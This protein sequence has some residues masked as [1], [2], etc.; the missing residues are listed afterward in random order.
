M[1][2][3]GR[4]LSCH[5]VGCSVSRNQFFKVLNIGFATF[6]LSSIAG[7]VS[8]DSRQ[9]ESELANCSR[10]VAERYG[11]PVL[12]IELI[13]KHLEA[14]EVGKVSHNNNDSYDMGP[15]QINSIHL[16]ELERYGYTAERLINDGCVNIVIGGWLLARQIRHRRSFA[17]GLTAYH[18]H[19][20]TPALSYLKRAYG[21]LLESPLIR[22]EIVLK[23]DLRSN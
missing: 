15:M 18:S 12:L 16:P 10:V 5:S 3:S 19:T 22:S 4:T 8:A 1:N 2:S 23:T 6:L 11:I 20:R 17:H 13:R 14:G 21:P 9:S 7:H